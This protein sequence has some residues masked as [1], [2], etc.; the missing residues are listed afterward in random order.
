MTPGQDRNL[1]IAE[2][3]RARANLARGVVVLDDNVRELKAALRDANIL[4]VVPASGTLA[5]EDWR[6]HLL[7]HRILV[8]TAPDDF[9][10]DAPVY[11]YGIIALNKLKVIDS[12]P[13]RRKNRTVRLISRAMS[14]YK[15][16][17]RGAKFLLEI[18]DDGKHLLEELC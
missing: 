18:R 6:D 11:E 3:I 9:K 13:T 14:R 10:Y 2:Q 17:A 16:W 7:F 8:T 15:L 4:V 12:A 1:R 5:D